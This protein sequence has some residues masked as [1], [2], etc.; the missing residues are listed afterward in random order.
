MIRAENRSLPE[1]TVL[2]LSSSKKTPGERWSWDTTTRSVPLMMKVPFS[3]ISGS[4]PRYTSW[5]RC[6]RMVRVFA[7]LSWSYTTRRSV[8]LSGMAKVMPRSWHS[9]T[10]YFGSPKW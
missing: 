1:A 4:S 10:V 5:P 3:V 6:S 9:S 7:S 2:P 8:T